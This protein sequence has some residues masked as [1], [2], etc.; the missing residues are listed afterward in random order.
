VGNRRRRPPRRGL[1]SYGPIQAKQRKPVRLGLGGKLKAIRN[2][3]RTLGVVLLFAASFSG[4]GALGTV[5]RNQ[6]LGV[7]ALVTTGTVVGVRD[8]GR[9]SSASWAVEFVPGSGQAVT[10]NV[11]QFLWEPTRQVGDVVRVRYDPND[12]TNYARDDSEGQS[13]LWPIC[14][15]L[16]A[17]GSLAIGVAGLF[18]R[19]PPGFRPR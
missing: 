15:A 11:S 1:P 17:V 6:H 5:D 9:Y 19:M 4:A 3:Q 2:S 13:V 10:A 14:L 16:L 18:R 12:P 8:G 7:G